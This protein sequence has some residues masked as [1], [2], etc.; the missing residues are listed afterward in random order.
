LADTAVVLTVTVVAPVAMETEP[1][2][3]DPHVPPDEAQFPIGRNKPTAFA[4]VP[5]M[6]TGPIMRVPWKLTVDPVALLIPLEH[7]VGTLPVR[8]FS[9]PP[10]KFI[11]EAEPAENKSVCPAPDAVS[12]R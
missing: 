7:A 12:V 6:P 2:F 3:P 10:K 4:P 5:V 8:Q 1:L 9:E 11:C